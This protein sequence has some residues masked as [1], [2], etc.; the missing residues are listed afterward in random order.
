[1]KRWRVYVVAF[2]FFVG[3]AII[4]NRLFVIQ[5]LQSGYYKALAMGQQGI[6]VGE[7]GKIFFN[8]GE[9]L[10]IN[11]VRKII[12][13]DV[14]KIADKEAAAKSVS[15]ILKIE[16]K[17]VLKVI[18]SD[19]PEIVVNSDEEYSNLKKLDILGLMLKE[20]DIRE[21]PQGAFAS[22]VV[23]FVGGEGEGQYGLEGYYEDI[24]EGKSALEEDS[25]FSA[26]FNGSD[27]YLTID[28]KIQDFAE[29][30]LEEAKST[31]SIEG[32]QIIVMDPATG[33]ILAL[34]NYPNFDPNQYSKEKNFNVFQNTAVQKLFEPGSIF[35]PLTMAAAIDQGKI[36]PETTYTD[37]GS[38]SS[39]RW[40]I[41]NFGKK[42]YGL[43]TMTQVLE[44]SINTGAVFA[45]KQLGNDLFLAYV[46]KFGFFEPTG[47]DLQKEASSQNPE[48]KKG[49][50]VNYMTAAFGQG[51]ELT[52]IQML[53]AY[54]AIP[55]GGKMVK[56]YVVD[57]IVTDGK[58]KVISP[59][60]DK[61]PVIS[62]ETASK[63][64]KM[65]VSVVDNGFA[66]KAKVPGYYIAG[67]T[68]TAQISF[69]AI[70]E[71]KSGYSDKTWQTF[72]GFAPAF[73]PKFLM[74]VKLDNPQ[75]STAEYS[76]VP[77]F[78]NV[79]KE[80]L[81]Y[82]EIPPDYEDNKL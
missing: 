18:D 72:M 6:N 69:S 9:P 47:I 13:F 34:A 1:M 78:K 70:N 67:K 49:Y 35:K 21:Y 42:S 2:I 28:Y 38:V 3:G 48:L 25:M 79:A 41:Y 62:P 51:I 58:T 10:A 4:L 66:K 74:L 39:G 20:K 12:S 24:L 19:D 22:Q 80:I 43:K 77:V 46:K 32:G 44:N 17:E 64:V 61:D 68:G 45:E 75:S 30:A 27:I 57:K 26:N 23:G 15:S 31:L 37:S 76:S 56:P 16:E 40:T 29:K 63:V 81:D 8:K 54:S 73:S 14:S 7:R 53:R 71:A 52:P 5:I 65:M 50:E 55:N 36:T 33:R 82:L 11:S 60:V 59:Q